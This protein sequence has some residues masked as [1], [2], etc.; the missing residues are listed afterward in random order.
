[1]KGNHI[2]TDRT[3]SLELV[4]RTRIGEPDRRIRVPL[5]LAEL[6]Q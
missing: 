2:S 4:L 5:D 6:A 3:T 1:V